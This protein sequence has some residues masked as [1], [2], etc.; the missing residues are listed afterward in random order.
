MAMPLHMVDVAGDYDAREFALGLVESK[1]QTLRG[2]EREGGKRSCLE[3][4]LSESD[5]IDDTRI[6]HIRLRI[7]V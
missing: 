6:E 5:M 7:H 4:C 1:D 3:M 2:N